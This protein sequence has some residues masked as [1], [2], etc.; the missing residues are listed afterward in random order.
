MEKAA[1]VQVQAGAGDASGAVSAASAP[2]RSTG[3]KSKSER[4]RLQFNLIGKSGGTAYAP[5]H[6]PRE[7]NG[8]W[9]KLDMIGK[10]GGTEG[11]GSY[12]R[13]KFNLIGRGGGDY[14]DAAALD[15]LDK[16]G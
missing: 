14:S 9:P 12:E 6:T 3:G 2:S 7:G 16:S 8:I 10:S 5:P 1:R 13:P 11:G 4:P 15:F